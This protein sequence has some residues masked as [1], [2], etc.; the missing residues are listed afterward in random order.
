M[1]GSVMA[2]YMTCDKWQ[3]LTENVFDALQLPASLSQ[4]TAPTEGQAKCPDQ[5]VWGALRG[6]L[7]PLAV[8]CTLIATMVALVACAR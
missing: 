7:G 3:H 6:K 5:Y 1:Q 2:M 4:T 8:A